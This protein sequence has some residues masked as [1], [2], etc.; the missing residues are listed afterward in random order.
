MSLSGTVPFLDA[1]HGRALDRLDRALVGLQ[2][3]PALANAAAEAGF[4]PM[5][6]NDLRILKAVKQ[7]DPDRASLYQLSRPELHPGHGPHDTVIVVL[8]R[9][10]EIV[11]SGSARIRW[12]NGTLCEAFERRTLLYDDVMQAPPAERII[13]RAAKAQVIR[14]CHVAV[15]GGLWVDRRHSSADSRVIRLLVRMLNLLATA[16]FHWSYCISVS[17]PPLMRHA[18]PIYG[19]DGVDSGVIVEVDGRPIETVLVH[20]SRDRFLGN[21]RLP[22]Y[23]QPAVDLHHPGS[24]DCDRAA[25]A[26]T[27]AVHREEVARTFRKAVG[28]Q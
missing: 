9:D 16:N 6:G 22:A 27:L 3:A 21:L 15:A 5:V 4:V 24:I 26:A 20:A 17:H 18:F 11:A 8:T 23:Q 12:V 10:G 14:D 1:V 2:V 25:A 13:C 19:A 28:R 7:G